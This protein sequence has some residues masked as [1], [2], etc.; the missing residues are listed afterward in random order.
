MS[1]RTRRTNA[2]ASANDINR[3]TFCRRASI[4]MGAAMLAPSMR[5]VVLAA[6]APVA[7]T[8]SGKISGVSAD[9]VHAFKGVPYGASTAGRNRFMPPQKPVLPSTTQNFRW[10]MDP[11]NG[12]PGFSITF[13][14]FLRRR[15]SKAIPRKKSFALPPTRELTNKS[16]ECRQAQTKPASYPVDSLWVSGQSSEPEEQFR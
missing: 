10:S 6:D 4:A 7:E 9:G 12:S 5:S 13:T 14:P 1:T 16:K 3:R 2:A 15:S 8:T 11:M